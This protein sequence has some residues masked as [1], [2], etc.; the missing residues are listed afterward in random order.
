M[1]DHLRDH[2]AVDRYNVTMVER[3]FCGGF[4]AFI[5]ETAV[6]PLEVAKTKMGLSKLKK[7]K[8]IL[9]CL[10]DSYRRAGIRGVYS[11]L[12]LSQL[13]VFPMFGT[14]LTFNSKFRELV[15]DYMQNHDQEPS[16]AVIIG[17]ASLASVISVSVVSP[18]AI[19]KT[20]LQANHLESVKDRFKGPIDVA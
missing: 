11:G 6:Y 9:D 13:S 17:C 1:F 7:Y 4:A 2:C 18:L 12:S 16:P 14:F 20:R 15:S 3:F 8:G 10:A 5:A 19:I